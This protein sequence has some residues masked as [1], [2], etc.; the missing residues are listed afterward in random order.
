[1]K[2]KKN[3]QWRAPEFFYYQK[4]KGWSAAMAIAAFL[5]VI[6]FILLKYY[7]AAVVIALAAIVIH[8]QAHAKP[9]NR[10]YEILPEGIKLDDHFYPFDHFRAF[11]ISIN[12]QGTTLYLESV[13]RFSLPLAIHLS[14]Q[15]VEE[16]RRL[17]SGFLPEKPTT[18]IDFSEQMMRWLRL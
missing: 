2:S 8:R 5:L 12:E 17:L 16:I 15:D 10:I 1:M 4:G 14:D 3:W 6:I 18:A 11:W 13:R 7:L 9:Q